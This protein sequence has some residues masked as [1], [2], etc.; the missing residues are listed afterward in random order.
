MVPDT[1]ADKKPRST[2]KRRIPQQERGHK[3]IEVILRAAGAEIAR[4]GLAKLTTKRIAEAAG[5]SVGGLYEYFPNKEAVVHALVSQWL[6]QVKDAVAAIHPEKT[7]CVDLLRYLN[8]VYD[9][10][11]PLYQQVPG[12]SVLISLLSSVPALKA[13][14]D[15]VD[16]QVNALLTDAMGRLVP[17]VGHGQCSATARTITI[18]DHHLLIASLVRDPAN[19]AVFDTNHRICRHALAS[20]LMLLNE[21]AAQ[22]ASW[23]APRPEAPPDVT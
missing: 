11:R 3:T 22:P 9:A 23:P 15:Q 6:E 19:A 21:Q 10:V 12:V 13:L 14:E 7:G 16:A 17:H 2:A 1:G 18:L 8:M 4:G 5:M 20:H